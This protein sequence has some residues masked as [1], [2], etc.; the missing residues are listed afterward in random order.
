MDTWLKIKCVED[1]CSQLVTGWMGKA[2][3]RAKE[4]ARGKTLAIQE[5]FRYMA[6]TLGKAILH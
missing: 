5:G 3:L 4:R 6:E 1:M 2:F